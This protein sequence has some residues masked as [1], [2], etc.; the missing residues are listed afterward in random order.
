MKL[1]LNLS[2]RIVVMAVATMFAGGAVYAAFQ[3]V[4]PAPSTA[5]STF[6]PQGSLLS[7]ESPDFAALLKTWNSSAEQR[8]WLTSDNYAVF[9]RSRLFS[10]LS[11]AQDEFATSAEL[12]PDMK[13]L[14]QVAGRQSIFAWYDIGNLQFLYITRMSAAT[15]QQTELLK[16]RGKFQLRKVGD[17][18]F[19]LRTQGEPERTVAFAV[20]GEY[21]LLATREDLVANA[22]QLMQHPGEASLHTEP[23]Y[24]TAIAAAMPAGRTQPSL[25]MTLNLTRILPSPYF[26]SYWIQQNIAELK[27]YSSAVS[28]LYL[29]K[30][31]FRE[32]RVLMPIASD[33]MLQTADLAPV[34]Q[35]LPAGAGVYRAT[36]QPS[37]AQIL[38]VLNDKLLSR[39]PSFY[40]DQHLAPVA[41]LSI[42]NAGSVTDLDTRIDTLP[43]PQQPLTAALASL[44][45]L[46]EEAHPAAMLVY[47]TAS[48]ASNDSIFQPVHNAVVLSA[49]T[50]WNSTALQA[51]LSEALSSHLTVASSGL[52]WQP[53]Q[54]ADATWFE[55]SGLQTFAFAIKGDRLILATDP[56]TLLR[57]L[58]VSATVKPVTASTIAGF[59]HI[60]ER[61]PLSRLTSLLDHTVIAPQSDDS[62]PAF[63]SR[64][65]VSLSNTFQS[66]DSESFTEAPTAATAQQPATIHQTVLY[67]WRAQP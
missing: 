56:E 23:W 37:T 15:S 35:L 3:A 7:I 4:V 30:Q 2:P 21:L 51:A 24:T 22:L 57:S 47:S 43:V 14:Q 19:Y 10:R 38:D 41:D 65:M 61:A 63:F 34:L 29:T 27:A 17:D 62:S 46:L 39:A 20:H 36:A 16:Q 48:A 26:R 32:E 42:E 55:L 50:P 6:V 52:V 25:R 49:A 1:R 58:G 13:F 8:A 44:Q 66:L 40:R 5:L 54:E 11:D 59:N 64:N 9:S 67:Q 28:D 53:H 12:A 60:A 45:A 31:N 33:A 18:S